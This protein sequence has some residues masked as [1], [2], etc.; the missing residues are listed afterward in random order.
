MKH[1]GWG[2]ATNR[3]HATASARHWPTPLRTC[4]CCRRPRTRARPN[5][6]GGCWRF[7]DRDEF[8]APTSVRKEKVVPFVIRT[9]KRRAIT[10][11]GEPLFLPR[12]TKLEPVR[13]E[14][15]STS[16]RSTCTSR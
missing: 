2:A 9:E 4:C 1:I 6:S 7:L 3:S 11:R 13:W 5:R 16:S 10:D 8:I 14:D 15:A 12:L